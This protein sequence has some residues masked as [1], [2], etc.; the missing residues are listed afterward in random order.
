MMSE[1][2]CRSICGYYD[3]DAEYRNSGS[4]IFRKHCTICNVDLISKYSTCP[5][6]YKS[7]KEIK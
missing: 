6:C 1:Y 7:F 5:C 4:S 2:Y 3:P